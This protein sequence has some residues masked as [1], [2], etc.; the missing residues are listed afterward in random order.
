VVRTSAPEAA[1]ALYGQSLG[2]RLALDRVLGRTRMLFFRI[3][4]VTLEVVQN[5]ALG[6]SDTFY[7]LAYRVRDIDAAHTRMRAAG[8]DVSEI[9]EGNKPGTHVYTVRDGSCS[10]PT[11]ILRD[12]SRD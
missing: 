10:V 2:I 1:I 4:G 5:P 11:L 6:E 8:L 12:P 7:G 3:G 9:R